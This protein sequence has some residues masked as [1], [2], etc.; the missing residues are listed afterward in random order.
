MKRL[1]L[2]TALFA[3]FSVPAGAGILGI[4]VLDNGTVIDSLSG[5][6]TGTAS[7]TTNDTAFSNITVNVQGAP[8]LPNA[9]LSTVTL[10]A[11]ASA[12]FTGTHN[13]TIDV[14]QTAVNG[15]GPVQST[16]TIN[17]LIGGPG[18][19]TESTFEGG[20]ST[21]LGNLLATHTFP[22]GDVNDHFG[23]VSNPSGPFTADAIEYAIAFTA[24]NQSFGGSAE[25]TNG[26]PE[27]S[28]WTM[29]AAGFGLFGLMERAR[30]RRGR[31]PR[32][33]EASNA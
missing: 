31:T 22:V 7:L 21:T 5:I 13:L 6:T 1:L 3:A 29:L 28:T 32:F 10:D 23:P 16:F 33:M 20:S 25:L 24:A 12:G 11:T 8:V 2:S 15:T 9:D 26:I 17:G 4:N 30:R 27:P 18:P 14:F 19:T